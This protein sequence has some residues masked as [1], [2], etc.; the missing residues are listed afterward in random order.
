MA[1]GLCTQCEKRRNCRFLQP[2]TWVDECG[3]F[4]PRPQPEWPTMPPD[5]A[6]L[7]PQELHL[8]A[9]SEAHAQGS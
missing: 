2:G 7:G 8:A 6:F 9:R 5:R 3:S 4:V 1:V